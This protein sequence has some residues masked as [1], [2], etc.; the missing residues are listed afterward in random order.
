M[1]V[2]CVRL[3]TR[4]LRVQHQVS[5]RSRFNSKIYETAIQ[6][7]DRDVQIGIA[8]AKDED[9]LLPTLSRPSRPDAAP[10]ATRTASRAC[11]S[12]RRAST[13]N[14]LP[15]IGELHIMSRAIQQLD[16]TS[17]SSSLILWLTA[18]WTVFKLSA[19]RAKL[20][21]SAT[22]TKLVSARISIAESLVFF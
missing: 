19:A 2:N 17:C 9:R 8:S 13:R 18:D 14:S 20:K 7:L 16:P 3:I 5:R 21:F 22:A 1:I 15:R 10:R 11:E 12:V 6:A 4:I